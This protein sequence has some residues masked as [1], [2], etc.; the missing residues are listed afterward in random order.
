MAFVRLAVDFHV[1]FH[2][3]YDEGVFWDSLGG[4]LAAGVHRVYPGAAGPVER[5]IVL[6][7]SAGSDYF[8]RWQSQGEAAAGGRRFRATGEPWSLVLNL[9]GQ[10]DLFVVA[11]RQ[12]V[13]VERLEV[14]TAGPLRSI[15]DGLPLRQVVSEL[16]D[17][18][19]LAILPWGAGK[20]LGGR[21]RL[22]AEVAYAAAQTTL[23]LADN[24]ARPRW[25]PAPAAFRQQSRSGQGVLRGSDPLPLPGEERRAGAFAS[26]LAGDFDRQRP[27]HSLKALLVGSGPLVDL[28]G[29][30]GTVRFFSR[31]LGLRLRK[32]RSAS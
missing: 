31:Q 10:T 6:T 30:D 20:W 14:L 8:E 27:L 32:P 17:A 9:D 2:P 11:G 23:F 21:G 1:H 24:P 3:G 29:R 15:P 13:T 5:L 25:W 16:T 18:G 28:G 12:I 19:E 22:V 26:L 7:E 4:N